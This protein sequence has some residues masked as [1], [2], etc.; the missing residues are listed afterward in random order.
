MHKEVKVKGHKRKLSNGKVAMVKAHSVKKCVGSCSDK[1]GCG[2]E[3]MNRKT[4][5]HKIHN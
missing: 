4:K 5:R 2:S 1:K 3:F